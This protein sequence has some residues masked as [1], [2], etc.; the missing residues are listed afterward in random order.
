MIVVVQAILAD[1]VDRGMTDAPGDVVD[2]VRDTLIRTLATDA[3]RAAVE[4][5]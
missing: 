4:S 3:G 2:A 1:W 5:A